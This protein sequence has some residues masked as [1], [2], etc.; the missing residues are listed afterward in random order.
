MDRQIYD[1]RNQS[2]IEWKQTNAY[3]PMDTQTTCFISIMLVVYIYDVGDDYFAVDN[4]WGLFTGKTTSPA[5]R[6]L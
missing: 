4:Q 3:I 5:L 6:I 1:S 2:N